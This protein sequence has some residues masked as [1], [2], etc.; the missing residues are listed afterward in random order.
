MAANCVYIRNGDP[1]PA[2]GETF[3]S[4][5]GDIKIEVESGNG[6]PGNG[7]C[8]F[9]EGKLYV[10]DRRLLFIR[11]GPNTQFSSFS[12]P[13]ALLQKNKNKNPIPLERVHQ[14]RNKT[15]SARWFERERAIHT[16][17][18]IFRAHAICI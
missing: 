7:G 3:V 10:T 4:C 1:V 2:V 6:F 16:A 12:I 11:A 17:V 9:G 15:H 14:R 13:F 18:W 5:D 8:Y